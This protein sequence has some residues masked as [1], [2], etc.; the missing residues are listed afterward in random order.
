VNRV[1]QNRVLSKAAC[2]LRVYIE[3]PHQPLS[4]NGGRG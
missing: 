3:V 2:N 1:V 4:Y